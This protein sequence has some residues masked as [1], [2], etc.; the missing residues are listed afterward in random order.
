MDSRDDTR[1]PPAGSPFHEAVFLDTATSAGDTLMVAILDF[2][3]DHP[4]GDPDG[5]VWSPI[6]GAFPAAGDRALVAESDDGS[7][8]VLGWRP[9]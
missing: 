3:P 4:F 1:Q 8:W 6:G 2:S 7:W 5:V 9:S